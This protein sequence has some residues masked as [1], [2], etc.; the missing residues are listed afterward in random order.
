MGIIRD[1]PAA[2]LEETK[3][4]RF[5]WVLSVMQEVIMNLFLS[6]ITF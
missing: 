2:I 5:I 6:I 3:D 4:R 1:G